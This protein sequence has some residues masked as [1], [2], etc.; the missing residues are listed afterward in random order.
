MKKTFIL[1]AVMLFFSFNLLAQTQD[2]IP[3]NKDSIEKA[4]DEFLALLD[5]AKQPKS[6]WQLS[7]GASNTQFSVNN[8]ALNA[9]QVSKGV[10]LIPT[11]MYYDKSGLSFTYNNFISINNN[12]SGIVQ[13]SITP[14]YDFSKD[15]RFDFGFSYT[16]FIGN[17]NFA[18]ISSPYQNDFYG[19]LQYNKWQVEPSLAFGYS[20]GKFTETS[21]TDTSFIL[22]RPFRPDTTIQYTIFDTLRVKLRDFSAILSARKE[23]VFEMKN[24]NNYITFTPSLLLFFARNEYEVEYSSASALS[25]RTQFFLQSRPLLREQFLREL[26]RSFSG[27]NETRNF[28]NTTSFQLQSLGLNLEATLYLKKFY[29]NPQ[30]YFDYYFPEADQKLTTIFTLQAGFIL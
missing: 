26:K 17:K 21:K 27:L 16:R 15:K 6:Y 12:N 5:S 7:L 24:A 9:Q 13:H 29:I 2:S 3:V 14:A 8:V 11:V 20:T 25:P 4:V 30:V 22:Q 10:T 23:F 1:P 19:Y 18:Q 28:L